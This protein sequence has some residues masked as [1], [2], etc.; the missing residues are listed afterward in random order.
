MSEA[1]MIGMIS[2]IVHEVGH[3]WFPMIVSSDERKWMWM[4]EGLNSFV[5]QVT[6]AER[7]PQYHSLV[8]QDI[9]PYM[10]GNQDVMRPIM[11]TSDVES[12]SRL[13]ANYYNKPAVGLQM[14]RETIVGRELFDQ[15]FKEYSTRWMYKHPNPGD[16]FRTLSDATGTN[17]DWFIRGWFFTTDNV[18]INLDKV[19]WYQL[20]E[21]EVSVENKGK[22]VKSKIS[23]SSDESSESNDFSN[24]PEPFAVRATPDSHYGGFLSRIDEAKMRDQL[25]GKNIYEL[26][27]TN[28]GGLVMPVIIEWTYT[29]GSKEVERLPA[30]IWQLNEYKVKRTFLKDKEVSS[31]KIDPNNELADVNLSN[32]SFPRAEEK[33]EFDEFKKD[34]K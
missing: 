20:K 3:N 6:M 10:K 28:E 26:T 24:G 19:K 13:G 31:I 30:E 14:L 25:S 34:S 27:F 15:A 22:K 11:T 23:G 1:A 12:L 2:V 7:Y 5:E 33:S 32:N 29:D 4:D 18:D 17:M 8:P 21:E 9:V 16:L